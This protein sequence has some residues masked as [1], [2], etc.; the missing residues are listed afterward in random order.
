VRSSKPLV[1][2]GGLARTFG[3]LAG[4]LVVTF[5][6]GGIY[7]LE[8]GGAALIS[9]AFIITLAAILLFYLIK[10]RKRP[11]TTSVDRA[12]DSAAAAV[13]PFFIPAA[14]AARQDNLRNNLAYQ[15]FYVDHCRIRP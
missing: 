11:R 2:R 10:P 1:V 9:G 8:A 4:F 14:G 6:C 7:I 13:Q 5:L 12:F 15:R 3:G